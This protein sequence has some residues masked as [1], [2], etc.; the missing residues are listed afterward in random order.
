M[1][2]SPRSTRR[3]GTNWLSL[4]ASVFTT[5]SDQCSAT[6]HVQGDGAVDARDLQALQPGALLDSLEVTEL[7]RYFRPEEGMTN[8]IGQLAVGLGTWRSSI[9]VRARPTTSRGTAHLGAGPQLGLSSYP[10]ITL[11]NAWP[12]PTT[13]R[14][15]PLLHGQRAEARRAC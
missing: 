2:T 3:L 12:T 4:S 15:H 9:G 10:I 7:A 13:S 5:D 14:G 6:H 8:L 1:R 11:T